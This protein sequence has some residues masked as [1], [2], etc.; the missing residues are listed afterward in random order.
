M[1]IFPGNETGGG[2]TPPPEV[3]FVVC[4]VLMR[5]DIIVFARGKV[6]GA[7]A[8]KANEVKGRLSLFSPKLKEREFI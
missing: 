6:W 1:D 8:E 7:G 4:L 5:P 3:L 2:H